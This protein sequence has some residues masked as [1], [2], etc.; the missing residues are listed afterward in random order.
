M[1]LKTFFDFLDKKIDLSS[2]GFKLKSSYAVEGLSFGV[3]TRLHLNE[4]F[5]RLN[6]FILIGH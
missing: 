1:Q 3:T 5:Y 4:M 6:Y 2:T